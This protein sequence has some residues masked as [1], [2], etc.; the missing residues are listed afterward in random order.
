[1]RLGWIKGKNIAYS[2]LPLYLRGLEDGGGGGGGVGGD[3]GGG[4]G[5]GDG[6]GH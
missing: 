6:G 2:L 4:G 3:G 5:G 1:M